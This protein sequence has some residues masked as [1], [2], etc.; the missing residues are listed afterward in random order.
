MAAVLKPT[1]LL[2]DDDVGVLKA[3]SRI[4]APEFE[5]AT[6]TNGVEAVDRVTRFD[7]DIVVLDIS[8]P[9]L[10]GFETATELRRVG[11]LA[12]L[13][14]LTSH[15]NDAYVHDAIESG[16]SGYVMKQSAWST[17]VPALHHVLAGRQFLPNLGP[18]AQT[19]R[20]AHA[21]HCHSATTAWLDGVAH[22]LSEALHDGDVT[23]VVLT[24]EH[25]DALAIRLVQRHWNLAE[26]HTQG[27]YLLFDVDD[28]S[29]RLIRN[30]RVDPD[31][32]AELIEVLERSR[33]ACVGGPASRVVIVGEI[34]ALLC[35]KGNFAAAL[36][37]EQAWDEL[38]RPL[39]IL[40][41]CAY[42]TDWRDQSIPPDVMSGIWTHHG[43]ITHAD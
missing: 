18:L 40:T 9:G 33:E 19:K 8:M 3:I 42:P 29:K 14:F 2:V 39:P 17:L 26:L 6:V 37:L 16:A 25:R 41:I 27:R 10:N 20:R 12:K 1:V 34:S 23:A 13:V 7:P 35:R 15:R 32:V 22:M 30:A 43:V 4:V 5:V 28:A 38:T 31:S 11:S 24:P 36:Q 21:C